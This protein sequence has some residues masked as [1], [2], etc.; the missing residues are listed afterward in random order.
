MANG[1]STARHQRRR[2]DLKSR[3]E[4]AGK[5]AVTNGGLG[6]F[7]EDGGDP[8]FL[9]PSWGRWKHCAASALSGAEPVETLLLLVAE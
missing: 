4:L 5:V 8:P 3:C 6:R 9:G 2:A 1:C 7:S